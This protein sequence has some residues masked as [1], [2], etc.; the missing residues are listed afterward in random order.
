MA[1]SVNCV[2]FPLDQLFPSV[3]C[4]VISWGLFYPALSIPFP[5][6]YVRMDSAMGTLVMS[7]SFISGS[8]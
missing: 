7:R 8:R 4:F 1:P 3:N 2:L 5:M 6:L